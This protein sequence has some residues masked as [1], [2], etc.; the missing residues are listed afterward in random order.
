MKL[1]AVG[2]S[3][4]TADLAIRERV[5]L[6]RA[7]GAGR[8]AEMLEERGLGEALLLSTCNRAELYVASENGAPLPSLR[9]VF[10]DLHDCALEQI[11][12]SLYVLEEEAAV[13]HLFL[14]AAG[15]DS[16]VL[17]ETEIMGQIRQAL[18]MARGAGT[19]GPLL[20]RLGERALAVGKRART[21]TGIDRG[22][23]SVASVAVELALEVFPDLAAA[24]V[25]LLG[26]GDT[27][28]LVVRR[29]QGQGV[30]ELV[31]SSRTQGRAAELTSR[32]G[33]RAVAFNQFLGELLQADLVISSTSAPHTL[34]TAEDMRRAVETEARSRFLIDLAVPRDIDPDVKGLPGVHLYDL[35]D[36]REVAGGREQERRA[37]LPRVAALAEQEAGEFLRWAR[38]RARL[39][40]VLALREQAETVRA[41]EVQR[42]LAESP[43]L[44]RREQ[45]AL[46]LMS[47]RLVRRLLSG[48]LAQR[49]AGAAGELDEEA[50]R[51][52]LRA[53]EGE[54]E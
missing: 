10:A 17:G 54:D 53:A 47:K 32:L 23:L 46:H 33:G 43:E 20:G 2:L 42:L 7:E 39:P 50:M 22:C 45:K 36:L 6:P 27:A 41:Q 26:A 52:A 15:A 25:L 31:V 18:E 14:V 28:E 29:L 13:E 40:E 44:S 30:S 35:D 49:Q 51:L 34:I 48:P 19:A 8:L 21:E 9:E 3:H 24:R 38:S 11:G 12:D 16:M 5:A 4:R 37:E 1:A